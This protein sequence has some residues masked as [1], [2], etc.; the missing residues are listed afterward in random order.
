MA[1]A[2]V[3]LALLTKSSQVESMA[4]H[5]H[6]SIR[7]CVLVGEQFPYIAVVIAAAI[8]EVAGQVPGSEAVL[9]SVEPNAV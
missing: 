2:A 3:V 5:H 9:R 7:T 4:P 6:R 8:V 1:S